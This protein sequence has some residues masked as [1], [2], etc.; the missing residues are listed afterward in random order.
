MLT[1]MRDML[2]SKF[3]GLLFALIIVS[4]GVWGITDIFS[5]GLGANFAKAGERTLSETQLDRRVENYLRRYQ[6]STGEVV[7]R[8]DAVE[9]GIVDQLY[10]LEASRVANLGFA[11]KVGAFAPDIAVTRE[12]RG[13][14]AFQSPL[15]GGFDLE[16]YRQRLA[17]AQMT[18]AQFEQDLRDDLTLETLSGARDAALQPPA[19]LGRLQASYLGEFRDVA[20]IEIPRSALPEA[21]APTEEE[22][23]A[24]YEEN[25]DSFRQPERRQINLLTLSPD[26]FVHQVEL[27]EDDVRA[28]YEATKDIRFSSPETR[29]LSETIFENEAAAREALGLIAGGADPATL[30]API[31][32]NTRETRR[33]DLADAALAEEVFSPGSGKGSVFGPT[34]SANGVWIVTRVEDIIPGD[35]YPF[36][37]VSDIIRNELR[38]Q[39]AEQSYYE[40]LSRIGDLIGVGMDLAGMAEDLGTPLMSLAPVDQNGL[41]ASGA[42]YRELIGVDGLVSELFSLPEGRQAERRDLDAR[43]VMAELVEIIPPSTPEYEAIEDRVRAQF[44]A[45]RNAAALDDAA[46]AARERISSG[47]STLEAEAEALGL[48]VNR[49]ERGVSRQAFDV[50]IPQMALNAVFSGAEGD[51]TVTPGSSPNARVVV[52]IESIDRPDAEM[53]DIL[54]VTSAASLRESLSNDLAQA[55][56]MAIREDIGFEDDA[57]AFARYKARIAGQQ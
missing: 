28:F 39:Q 15:T 44:L 7:T 5:G 37:D 25:I 32:T 14:E 19:V 29:V 55:L 45:E 53:L 36:E 52:S 2:R 43:T 3:A 12:L 16:T 50:G 26:D 47:E 27:S 35:P 42:L 38:S 10:A 30:N 21:D 24:Y 56:E 4:M 23:R 31:S 51:V 8:E 17:S 9:Q 41:A 57:V 22:L 33:A 49:P 34:A 6:Q 1:M 11:E 40:A 20:W 46:E 18:S 54:A 13:I 48:T